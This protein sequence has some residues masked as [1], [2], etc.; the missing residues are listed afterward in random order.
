VYI[1][2]YVY[3]YDSLRRKDRDRDRDRDRSGDP[4]KSSHRTDKARSRDADSKKE[5]EVEVCCSSVL[6]FVAVLYCGAE[7]LVMPAQERTRS[8]GVLQCA[9]VCCGALQRVTRCR[10][11]NTRLR[12]IAL[13][14]CSLLQCV[15]VSAKGDNHDRPVCCSFLAVCC[16]VVRCSVIACGT[17]AAAAR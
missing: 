6:Q 1:Y 17:A 10:R 13:V 16:S 12:C 3:I 7:G 5:R 2:I 11:K 9:A 14:C 8:C 4:D 15:A